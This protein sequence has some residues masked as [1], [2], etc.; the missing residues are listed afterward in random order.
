MYQKLLN[1]FIFATFPLL[2]NELFPTDVKMMHFL[3][4]LQTCN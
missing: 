2:I 3:A 4:D 1:S